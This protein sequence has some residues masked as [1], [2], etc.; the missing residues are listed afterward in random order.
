LLNSVHPPLLESLWLLQIR[1]LFAPGFTGAEVERYLPRLQQIA[2]RFAASWA[3]AGSMPAW[4]EDIKLFTFEVIC[5]VVAG[6]DWE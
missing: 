4:G 2:E 5:A 1:K 3:A 6:I